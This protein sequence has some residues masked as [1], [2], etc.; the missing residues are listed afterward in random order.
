MALLRACA[1]AILIGSGTL[2]SSPAGTWR[3]DRAYPPAAAALTELR[4]SRARPELPPVAVVTARGS[5]DPAHPLLERGV[6]LLTTTGAAA[7][8]RTR[9]PNASEVVAVNDG[10]AV[11][12]AAAL[13]HLRERG[14]ELILSEAGPAVLGSLLAAH[15]VDELFLT[16]SSLLA[17]RAAAPRLGLVEG[18]ELLPDTRV[19]ASLRS[20]RRSGDHLLARYALAS[21]V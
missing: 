4:R 16:V 3:P 1:D 18:V 20:L 15:L 5:V 21:T 12:L 14:H 7:T 19:Q 17:G 11:D 13:A 10:D 9:V 8:L 6:T 2:R